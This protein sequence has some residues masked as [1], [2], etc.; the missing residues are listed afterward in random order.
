MGNIISSN[1][2]IIK[3][4]FIDVVVG[5][6]HG[7][8]G[9][10]KVVKY[11]IENGNYE[12]CVRFN[13]GPNAGHT[14]YHNGNKI[15]THQVPTGIIAPN[16]MC[17][18][19]S[20]CVIDFDKLLNECEQLTQAGIPR[21]KERIYISSHAHVITNEMIDIDNSNNKIGTTG[22]GIGPTYAAKAYRTGKRI[23]DI[24]KEMGNDF[25]FTLMERLIP[26]PE[27]EILLEGAQGIQLDIDW[28]DYPYVTS[29]NCITPFAFVSTG[30]PMSALRNVFGVSKIYDTYVGSKHFQGD[31]EILTKIQEYGQEYG[32]TTGRPR[33]INWLNIDKLIEAIQ[34]NEVST[35]IFNKCD[36]IK[37]LP[38]NYYYNHNFLLK[39]DNI[40]NMQEEITKILKFKFPNLEIIYSGN[41]ETIN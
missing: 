41:P 8:E 31:D 20:C 24:A 15:I 29:S 13:G 17:W 7:D 9:K 1:N 35:I 38:Y 19:S 34:I 16:I 23:A 2:E 27:Q 36:I 40:E 30:L 10:G 33:Q 18:L 32:S 39:N 22:S 26:E 3:K 21:V 25:P 28:G 37:L 6:Q 12:W 5:L 14:I 4:K 11:L